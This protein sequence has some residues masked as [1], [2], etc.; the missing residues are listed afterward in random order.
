MS[1]DQFLR[2]HL[3]ELLTWRSAHTE[4]ERVV[5]NVPPDARGACPSSTP[6]SLWQLLEHIRLSQQDILDFCTNPEYSSPQWPD[7]FWP[8]DPKPAAREDWQQSI[9]TYRRD[10]Q[11]LV[12]IVQD[13][14]IDL[15]GAI[16]HGEGQTYFREIVLVADHTS[17][18]LGQMVVLRRHLGIWPP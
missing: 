12:D 1:P 11:S 9:D 18:H 7:D 14:S 10:R 3:K 15:L 2:E 5:K 4:F 6:Y 17:Y 8:P 16:P 13:G